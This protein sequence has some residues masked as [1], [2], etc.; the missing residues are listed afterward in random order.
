[1]NGQVQ[2]QESGDSSTNLQGQTINIT[3]GISYSDA[4]EIALD[5]FKTNFPK[6]SDEAAEKV[7]S[8]VEEFT[9][10]FLE[11]LIHKG[12]LLINNLND[13]GI[14]VSLLEA[15][16]GYA[17][18]GDK[19]LEDLLIDILVERTS[20]TERNIDQIVLEESLQIASKLTAENMDALTINFLVLQ[21]RKQNM[22][23]LDNLKKY[24]EIEILP[25]LLTLS[26]DSSCYEHIEYSGCGSIMIIG[27]RNS[28][29]S[30]FKKNYKG[31]F[32]KGFDNENFIKEIGD[33]SE[34]NSLII[35]SLHHPEKLQ[36]NALDESTLNELANK[37]G[38]SKEKHTKLV[39]FFNQNLMEDSDVK[40]LIKRLVPGTDILFELWDNSKLSKLTLTTV[41]ISIAQANFRRRTGI[42]LDLSTWIK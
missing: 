10:N 42:K 33:L 16:K 37:L 22:T 30:I 34:Y 23:S 40:E 29:E 9:V 11:K 26:S 36:I 41:G 28:I 31:L 1:M 17:K 6:L 12:K 39:T 27:T 25:F 38:L 3:Q 20:I 15:Q 24:F 18:T 13:P 5:V 2:K 7:F 4:K 35:Q 19:D 8:R 21:T 32:C 14:Q